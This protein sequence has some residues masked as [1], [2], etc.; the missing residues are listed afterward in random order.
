M[1]NFTSFVVCV[2]PILLILYTVVLYTSPLHF[3]PMR[4]EANR[5]IRALL[6]LCSVGIQNELALAQGLFHSRP[7][8]T[9]R[10]GAVSTVS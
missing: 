4:H 8:L 1:M 2:L 6:G 10:C 3:L 9:E 7:P 5:L